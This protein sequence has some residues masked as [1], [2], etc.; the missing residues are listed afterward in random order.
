MQ[1]RKGLKWI[2]E[3]TWTRRWSCSV[4]ER[5]LSWKCIHKERSERE[6]ESGGGGDGDENSYS[7]FSEFGDQ[8]TEL[9]LEFREF[10]QLHFLSEM[11]HLFHFLNLIFGL[12]LSSKS[13]FHRIPATKICHSASHLVIWTFFL[14]FFRVVC[15]TRNLVTFFNGN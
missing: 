9:E 4:A 10:Q 6:R 13:N 7:K 1:P 8:S 15:E 14:L 3:Q 5:S 12:F 11:I 2:S